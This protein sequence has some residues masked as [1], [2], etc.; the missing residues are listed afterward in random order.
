MQAMDQ[1]TPE[2]TTLSEA[3]S[4]P[5]CRRR[6][7]CATGRTGSSIASC[8]GCTSIGG[9]LEE[10]SDANHPVL[11]RLRF[12]SISADNLDEFFMVRVAGLKPGSARRNRHGQR[13]RQ[14]R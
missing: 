14:S 6:G 9:V 5:R 7:S 12:L 13:R 1:K 11:E 2:I 10:A 3:R 4:P 8:R